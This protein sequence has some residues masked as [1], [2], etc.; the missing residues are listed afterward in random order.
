MQPKIS[1][2]IPIYNVERYLERCLKSVCNQSFKDIEIICINDGSTDRS[3]DILKDFAA[4][5]MRIRIIDKDNTGV[6]DCRNIGINLA[7]GRYIMFVDSDDWIDVSMIEKMYSLMKIHDLD[8]SICTY[9]REFGSYKKEK[10]FNLPEISLY[11]DNEVKDLMR[12][13]IGPLKEELSN[14]EYLDALGTVWGKL[15]KAEIIKGNTIK[16]IDLKEI[17]SAEDV[18][19]NMYFLNASIKV[20]FLNQPLYHYW[21][22]NS[23]SITSRYNEKLITQRKVF[24][25]YIYQ[26]INNNKLSNSYIK[27]LNNRISISVLGLGLNEL[28]EDNQIS[29]FKKYKNYRK[30]LNESYIEEANQELELSYFPLHWRLFY[31]CNKY[32][33]TILSYLMIVL[34]NSLRKKI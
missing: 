4:E 21:K 8:L 25:N 9:C 19:F 3:P 7:I 20:I 10:I 6:S 14:P 26:F 5:D 33:L 12:R 2:I 23:I 13:L 27:S 32:H 30:I 15:Y 28:A 11:T 17:G 31:F 1:V 34:I 16:F 22:V 29:L 24:F 18:L